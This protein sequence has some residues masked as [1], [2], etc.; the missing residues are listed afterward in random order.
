MESNSWDQF[1]IFVDI[2]KGYL[3]TALTAN[4]WFYAITG[5]IYTHYFANRKE[6]PYVK[7]SL[8]FPLI[9]SLMLAIISIFGLCQAFLLRNKMIEL[10]Q[11]LELTGAPLV[12]LLVFF[13]GFTSFFFLLVTFSSWVLLYK[14]NWIFKEE[15]QKRSRKT[16]ANHKRKR[17]SR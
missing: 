13:L 5:A 11:N 2:F 4:I 6:K 3:D 12:D 14:P 16:I 15:Q 17:F 7:Y 1:K 8:Y 9:L 10:A